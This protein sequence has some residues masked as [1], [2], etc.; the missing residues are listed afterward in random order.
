[1]SA[2]FF[3]SHDPASTSYGWPRSLC[4]DLLHPTALSSSFEAALRWHTR[5][6]FL[7]PFPTLGSVPNR[8]SESGLNRVVIAF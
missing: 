6:I 3:E 8:F 4:A 2:I 5:E 1:M 7:G